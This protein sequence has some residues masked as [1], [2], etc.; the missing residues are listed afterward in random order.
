MRG[1]Q[2]NIMPLH[3]A[4]LY[5]HEPSGHSLAARAIEEALLARDPALTIT[6]LDLSGG[7]HPWIGPVLARTYYGVVQSMPSLWDYL[8]DNARLAGK[9]R[10]LL[11]RLRRME[12]RRIRPFLES[13][14]PDAVVATQ[15]LPCNVIAFEKRAGRLHAPLIGVLTDFAAHAYWA[16]EGTDLYCVPSEETAADLAARGAPRDHILV[17]GIPIRRAFARLPGKAAARERLGLDPGAPVALVAGGTQGLGRIEEAV[18]ALQRVPGGVQVLVSC[19]TNEALYRRLK[20]SRQRGLHLVKGFERLMPE[21]MPAADILVGKPGGLTTAEALACG[22]PIV[23]YAPLPGQEEGNA[24][25]LA[26]HGA[27]IRA[28]DERALTRIASQLLV[29]GA[30]GLAE[31]A[32]AGR[33]LGRPDSALAIADAVLALARGAAGPGRKLAVEA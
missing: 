30:E 3:V 16:A 18:R 26:R 25:W 9:T 17:T 19:G 2:P 13:K 7:V 27:A 11:D 22:L 28:V 20:K 15:A 12:A 23:V 33:R 31:L 21:L 14:R 5:N 32:A 8:Y 29:A 1:T 24:R 4:L 10:Y 6:K